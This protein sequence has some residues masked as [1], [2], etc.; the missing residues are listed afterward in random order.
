MNGETKRIA[1]QARRAFQGEAWHGPSLRE[2]LDGIGAE[3]AGGHPVPHGHS[4]WELVLHVEAWTRAAIDAT[5]RGVPMPQDYYGTEVD[6]PRV[7][8]RSAPAWKNAVDRLSRTGQDF[9]AAI[10]TFPEGR[11]SEIVP[12]RDYDFYFLFHGVVQHCLYHGGQIALLKKA[13]QG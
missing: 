6:W 4:I 1:D 11:L 2:I 12:G 3:Q 8:D 5:T 10:E 9:V 13:V 7:A